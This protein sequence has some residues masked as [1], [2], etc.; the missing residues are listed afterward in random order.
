MPVSVGVVRLPQAL[1]PGAHL[2]VD[3][4]GR[5]EVWASGFMPACVTHSVT[6][7]PT[8]SL[9]EGGVGCAGTVRG[10]QGHGGAGVRTVRP[11]S[12][13]PCVCS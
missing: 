8:S 11:R 6:G 10:P 4:T 2:V 12:P 9:S 13:P 5:C 3:I 7:V 1:C